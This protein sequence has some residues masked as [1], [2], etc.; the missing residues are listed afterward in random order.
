MSMSTILYPYISF[1]PTKSIGIFSAAM[2]PKKSNFLVTS[3]G[4]SKGMDTIIYRGFHASCCLTAWQC[5]HTNI[6]RREL[7]TMSS[8]PIF[9]AALHGIMALITLAPHYF[10]QVQ[11]F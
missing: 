9:H 4:A 1:T 5:T 7:A 11:V 10:S 6:Q 3:N 8:Q 2:A